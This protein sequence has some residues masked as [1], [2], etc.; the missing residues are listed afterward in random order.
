MFTPLFGLCLLYPYV[1]S[2]YSE[3][4]Q[5]Y[6]KYSHPLSTSLQYAI[7]HEY[8][9]ESEPYNF[10]NFRSVLSNPTQIILIKIVLSL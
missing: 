3:L 8:F 5:H 2:I 1:N 4:L 9:V 7:L 6:N 10:I